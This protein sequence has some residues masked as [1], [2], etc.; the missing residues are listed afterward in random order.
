MTTSTATG[1]LASFASYAI[2]GLNIVMCK[3]IANSDVLSPYGLFFLRALGA[4]LLFWISSLFIKQEKVPGKDMLQILC[5]SFIG[6]LL[7]QLTFL[8]GIREASSIDSSLIST[9]SPIFTMFFAAYFI[10]EPITWKKIIG[11]VISFAGVT[12]LIFNSLYHKG[13]AATHTTPTGMILLFAN[14]FTFALYLGAFKPLIAHYN[15]ITFMKW[16]F[17]FTLIMSLPF[18][19]T[20]TMS[21]I[22]YVSSQPAITNHLTAIIWEITYVVVFATYFAYLLIPIGQK[23]IRPTLVSMYSYI[24][25]VIAVVISVIIGMDHLT[26]IKDLAIIMIFLGVAIVNRSR[27]I[28]HATPYRNLQK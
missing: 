13:N 19:L 9:L 26:W 7:P 14:C 21:F 10:K 11:V 24:Q 20:D 25:P 3:D 15:V 4:T 23:R 8:I 27:T 6:L 1:H 16:M 17:L 22:T 5:A 2:F 12:F 18:C 28:P